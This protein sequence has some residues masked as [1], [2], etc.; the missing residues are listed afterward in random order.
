MPW[1][2]YLPFALIPGFFAGLLVVIA[3]LSGWSRLAER[4]LAEREPEDGIRF[5]GQFFRIGWCDYNGCMTIRVCPDGLY[6]AVWP[7]FVGHPPLL[8]PWS[9]LRLVEE[10]RGRWFSF[11]LLE[12]TPPMFARLRLPLR[13]IEAGRPWLRP[14][15]NSV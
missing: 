4:F 14:S 7:I 3:K 15:E 12:V 10:Q 8:I 5:R 13:V 11:A 6:L 1:E 9:A 2:F